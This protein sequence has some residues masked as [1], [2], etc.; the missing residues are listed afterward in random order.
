[1]SPLI[2][3]SIYP[4]P[5]KRHYEPIHIE[6]QLDVTV[7]S[8]CSNQHN[9]AL[10]RAF[11]ML[12]L[13]NNAS[14]VIM[15]AC[16]KNISQGGTGLVFLANVVPSLGIKLSSPWW[17]DRVGYNTRM[18]LATLCMVLSF[19]LIAMSSSRHS[20]I[21]DDQYQMEWQLMGVA[22]ASAQCG[23]GEASLLAL[24]GKRDSQL[25][26]E[27][28]PESGTNNNMD[29][30]E[31]PPPPPKGKCLTCFSSGTG[32]A[33]VF[34]FFWK[35]F[36]NE[37]LG[38]SLSVTLW[39]AMSLAISYI[40]VYRRALWHDSHSEKIPVVFAEEDEVVVPQE[41]QALHTSEQEYAIPAVTPIDEMN[42]WQ[43]LYMVLSLWPYMVPLFVV[44]AAE[45]ALQAGTWTAIGFP[46]QDQEARDSFYE[47]SNWM[48]QAGVF[49]SRSSGTMYTAPMWVL[50]L[51]PALQSINVIFFSTVASHPDASWIYNPNVLY[52]LCFYVGLLGG[53]VYIS[54]YKR[55]CAD[56]PVQH[57][58]FSLSA[59]SVAEGAGILVADILGLFIQ[60]CLYQVNGLQGAVVTCPLR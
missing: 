21:L 60:S 38:F 4:H 36:W 49:V 7:A 27:E 32:I 50:W 42:G 46:L 40:S 24:A 37:W 31:E 29:P 28:Y 15:I 9:L 20:S 11:W 12:G 57:R 17:F 6:Q 8:S 35:W 44:Y 18:I 39:L 52:P 1:M 19:L 55:I 30:T 34:G 59:T 47:F 26:L 51:M 53:A 14:Y 10:F 13:L 56:L 22:L 45:Y 54:G 5:K 16:A 48:Y 23:L 3:G 43:R 33:G 25:H 2:P 58:E 41:S